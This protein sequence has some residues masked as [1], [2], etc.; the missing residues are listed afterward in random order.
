MSPSPSVAPNVE[1]TEPVEDADMRTPE[2]LLLPLDKVSSIMRQALPFNAKTSEEARRAMQ[3]FTTEYISHVTAEANNLCSDEKRK[4][5]KPEDLIIANGKLGF[6]S[7]VQPLCNFL[8][9][10]RKLKGIRDDGGSISGEQPWSG[11]HGGA[12][13]IEEAAVPPGIEPVRGYVSQKNP[14]GPWNEEG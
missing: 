4:T 13:V 14:H 3:E 8:Q 10:H 2:D 5:M 7:F 12:G 11:C 6:L 1:T 9:S